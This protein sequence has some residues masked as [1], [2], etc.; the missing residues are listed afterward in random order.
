MQHRLSAAALQ[1][2]DVEAE[3]ARGLLPGTIALSSKFMPAIKK[4][5]RH[6]PKPPQRLAW[7]LHPLPPGTHCVAIA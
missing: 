4:V 1:E 3:M 2:M 6:L 5:N 7:H